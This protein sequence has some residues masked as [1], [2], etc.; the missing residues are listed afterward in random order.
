MHISAWKL[1]SSHGTGVPSRRDKEYYRIDYVTLAKEALR[2]EADIAFLVFDISMQ[3]VRPG[4]GPKER[5][6]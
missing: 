2:K 6:P 1:G 5:R 3:W 4:F